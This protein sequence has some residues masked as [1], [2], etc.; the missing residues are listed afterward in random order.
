[1]DYWELAT[2][3]IK[4]VISALSN[5]KGLGSAARTFIEHASFFGEGQITHY[6]R[7][8]D[9]LGVLRDDMLRSGEDP[10]V[11]K[12]ANLLTVLIWQWEY[13]AMEEEGFKSSQDL[14]SLAKTLQD[15]I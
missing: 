6:P 5:A 8:S 12:I 7:W 10:L 1:M 4:T 9:D 13:G 3:E 2:K 14:A 11:C 15:S